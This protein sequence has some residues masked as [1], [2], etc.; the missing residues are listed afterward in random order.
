MTLALIVA[1]ARIVMEANVH[2]TQNAQSSHESFEVFGDGIG[3]IIF[4]FMD[5]T[6]LLSVIILCVTQLKMI[7]SNLTTNESINMGRYRHFRGEDGRI[8][9]YFDKG[10]WQNMMQFFSKPMTASKMEI[11]PLEIQDVIMRQQQ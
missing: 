1:I 3:I 10:T 7:A 2:N 5:S 9:N 4:L 6:L 11:E 8:K